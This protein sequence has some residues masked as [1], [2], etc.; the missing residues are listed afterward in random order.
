MGKNADDNSF[1]CKA[2]SNYSI[3]SDSNIIFNKNR[4]KYFCACINKDA[5]ANFWETLH[6]TTTP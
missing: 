3:Y 1:I 5:I 2:F 4:A 6:I